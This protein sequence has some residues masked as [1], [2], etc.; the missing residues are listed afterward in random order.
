VETGG[1]GEIAE[2]GLRRLLG[3]EDMGRAA[4]FVLLAGLTST[5]FN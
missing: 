3:L 2:M 1:G 5:S 4:A